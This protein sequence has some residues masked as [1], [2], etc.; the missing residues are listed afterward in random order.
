MGDAIR[1]Q[2]VF[3]SHSICRKRKHCIN[4]N[5][6]LRDGH[7]AGCFLLLQGGPPTGG[8]LLAFNCIPCLPSLSAQET[9]S[10]VT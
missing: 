2:T 10:Q 7:N 3:V 4:Q 9:G 1:A 8:A 5:Q 6:L